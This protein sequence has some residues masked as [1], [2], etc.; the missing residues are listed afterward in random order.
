MPMH[1]DESISAG[2]RRR[3]GQ[4]GAR[5]RDEGQGRQDPGPGN[6]VPRGGDRTRDFGG[7]SSTEGGGLIYFRLMPMHS[8]ESI[9][10]GRGHREG[11]A[12]ARGRDEGQG[13]A[14]R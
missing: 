5:G 14:A 8:D 11:Q 4:A 1:S 3:E 6:Q 9:S 2:R 10:T 13:R 12:G 7:E